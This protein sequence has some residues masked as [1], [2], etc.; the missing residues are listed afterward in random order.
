MKIKFICDSCGQIMDMNE[1]EWFNH[2]KNHH[3]EKVNC[4]ELFLKG[5]VKYNK[6]VK[7]GE[8]TTS[9]IK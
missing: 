2:L 5:Y 8:K 7:D 4:K 9:S 6:E 3:L 1:N